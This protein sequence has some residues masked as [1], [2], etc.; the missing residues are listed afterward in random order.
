MV[1]YVI[2]LAFLLLFAVTIFMLL[3]SW[4]DA[5]GTLHKGVIERYG[6]RTESLVTSDCP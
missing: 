4:R 5:D 6:E 1:E 2:A 3:V